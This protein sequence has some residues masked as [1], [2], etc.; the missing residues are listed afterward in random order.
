MN[1]GPRAWGERAEH[2]VLSPLPLAW[3]AVP[4]PRAAAATGSAIQGTTSQRQ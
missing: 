3:G 4:G 1:T 2:E